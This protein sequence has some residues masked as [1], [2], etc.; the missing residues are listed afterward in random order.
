[1]HQALPGLDLQPKS[2][3]QTQLFGKKPAR[4]RLH[5]LSMTGGTAEAQGYQPHAAEAAQEE[6]ATPGSA[7][8]GHRRPHAG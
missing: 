8:S 7:L 5:H 4:R 2:T 1:M 6:N 3:P